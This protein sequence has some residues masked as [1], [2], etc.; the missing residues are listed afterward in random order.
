MLTPKVTQISDNQFYYRY[1]RYFINLQVLDGTRMNVLDDDFMREAV[2][3]TSFRT[4]SH[5]L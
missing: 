3:Q 2:Q 4:I 1:L 5:F